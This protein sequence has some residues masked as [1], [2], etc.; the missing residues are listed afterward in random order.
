MSLIFTQRKAP[1]RPV[2]YREG[3]VYLTYRDWKS[4]AYRYS[5][6]HKSTRLITEETTATKPRPLPL[7]RFD[8]TIK[9][10][11][12][13]ADMAWVS[14]SKNK[15][16]SYRNSLAA[17][18]IAGKQYTLSTNTYFE[19][20]GAS[21]ISNDEVF[22]LFRARLLIN[23][24]LLQ[25]RKWNVITDS[26]VV[27]WQETVTLQH[28]Y[29]CRFINSD[30]GYSF[31]LS[32]IPYADETGVCE[33]DLLSY[34]KIDKETL[35]VTKT[36]LI[37][38]LGAGDSEFDHDIPSAFFHDDQLISI[39]TRRKLDIET[40]ETTVPEGGKY[41]TTTRRTD[42]TTEVYKIFDFVNEQLTL[43]D[44]TSYHA[45]EDSTE[46]TTLER[47]S[48]TP[49]LSYTE[50]YSQVI[51]KKITKHFVMQVGIDYVVYQ[52]I[53]IKYDRVIETITEYTRDDIDD[54]FSAEVVSSSNTNP[55]NVWITNGTINIKPTAYSVAYAQLVPQPSNHTPI[56]PLT[57]TIYPYRGLSNSNLSPTHDSGLTPEWSM[58]NC[59]YY[60]RF[61]VVSFMAA[62]S[63]ASDSTTIDE[64]KGKTILYNAETG[65]RQNLDYRVTHS[66]LANQY[67]SI[68]LTK[69]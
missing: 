52:T 28:S 67:L 31:L 43:R 45:I 53:E 26:W 63:A 47:I 62:E 44:E 16:V 1:D 34:F 35:A 59:G 14:K 3:G 49:P 15:A 32:I 20:F 18:A 5:F 29:L 13:A 42:G 11:Y 6:I 58:L 66:Q 22:V 64:T 23:S 39:L 12:A 57:D 61:M 27:L 55:T 24:T 40:V 48:D 30:G 19:F 56:I 17:V 36:V 50:R 65:Q 25:C 54:D 38:K 41:G 69:L 51:D 2:S 60:K 68:S 8:P 33:L 4:D 46:T 21:M 10:Y 37:P 9:E 7:P